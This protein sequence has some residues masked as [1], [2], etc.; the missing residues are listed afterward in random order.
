M[1]RHWTQEERAKQS[2][3]IHHWKPWERSTGAKTPE[4]KTKAS[5]NA[6][7]GGAQG[8]ANRLLVALQELDAA[9]VKVAKLAAKKYPNTFKRHAAW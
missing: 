7:K 2:A 8:K 4:G 3:L 6:Y 1:A 9:L 5:R